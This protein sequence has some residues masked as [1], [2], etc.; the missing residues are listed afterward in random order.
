MKF[1]LRTYKRAHI[2]PYRNEESSNCKCQNA[3]PFKT[4]FL[5]IS[6]LFDLESTKN[7]RASILR[8]MVPTLRR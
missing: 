5:P 2:E 8:V 7:L 1:G 6:A 3:I 4:L